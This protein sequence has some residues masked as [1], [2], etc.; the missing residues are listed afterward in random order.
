MSPP[1]ISH[2]PTAT[3]DTATINT[4]IETL[5]AENMLG[6]DAVLNR[7]VHARGRRLADIDPDIAPLADYLVRALSGGK[8]LRAAFCLWGARGAAGGDL[9][10]GAVDAA[11]AIELFHLGALIHDDVMDHSDRRR[12]MPTVH[13][14]FA[15]RHTADGLAGD[16]EAFGQAVAI[17]AGDLCLMWS[18]EVLADAVSA[19]SP[20]IGQRA[21]AVWSLM[22]DETVGGQYLD[23]LAQATPTTSLTRTRLV[24]HYKS[25]KYTVAQPLRL[26]GAL[27]GADDDLL[28]A[29]ESLGLIA[30]EAFQLRDDLL[31]VFGDV[32]TTGKPVIDDIREGKRTLLV[33]VASERADPAQ[34]L[35]LE[36]SLG[37]P[38]LTDD[39]LVAVGRV[40]HDTGAVRHVE[41]RIDDLAA[42]ALAAVETL[43]VDDVCR[44]ALA[45][46]V[47]RGIWRDS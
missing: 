22:R 10:A 28:D 8:R 36:R 32:A 13:R 44:N 7:H 18:D 20:E 42:E 27:A 17:L 40:L 34:R 15:D 19:A 30:G 21:R 41:D 33:A 2:A 4:A 14:R 5:W 9:P 25:A 31:G 47:S 16:P 12:G 39:D 43:P 29:Y 24:L 1:H 26:G 23:M 45:R 35:L 38:H 11:A 37:N 3:I 6:V 46:L